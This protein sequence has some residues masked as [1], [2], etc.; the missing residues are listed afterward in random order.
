MNKIVNINVGGYPF[1]I[2]SDAY[3]YL[4]G[5]LGSIHQHFEAS[6]GYDE[7]TGDIETRLAELFQDQLGNRPIVTQADVKAAVGIMGM[8][9]EF[10]AEPIEEFQAHS[11][12]KKGIKTGK[13]L[14]RNSED[15]VLGGVCSGLSAYF[16]IK[17]PLW[18]RLILLILTLTSIGFLAVAYILLWVIVPEAVTASDRLAMRGETVNVSNI[19]KII[20]EEIEELPK[21]FSEAGETI[22]K[23]FKS[24][25]K[26][27]R[28]ASTGIR[29][30]INKIFSLIA[31][32]FRSLLRAIGHLWR[33]LLVIVSFALAIALI[34]TWA[35][36]AISFVMSMP[37]AGYILPNAPWMAGL[38]YTNL[39]L[40]IGIPLLALFFLAMRGWTKLRLNNYWRAGLGAFWVVNVISLLGIG[41]FTARQFNAGVGEDGAAS[42]FSTSSDT[43]YLKSSH[44]TGAEDYLF[45]V[46]GDNELVLAD[47]H[48]LVEGVRIDLLRSESSQFQS[49]Q[50]YY[51]R[52]K[53]QEEAHDLIRKVDF[54][55]D[56]NDN[57]WTIPTSIKVQKGEKYRAQNVRLTIRIPD[58]KHVVYDKGISEAINR[59][60]RADGD[61]TYWRHAEDKVWTM[62]ESGLTC[63]S[64]KE[65]SDEEEYYY[66]NFT[67]LQIDGKMK[68]TIEQDYSS[69]I[70][71]DARRK[72]RDRIEFTQ[73]DNTLFISSD[74]DNPS[75]PIRLSIKMPDLSYL[76]VK[77][78]D[79]VTMK[80]F[81]QEKMKI[82]HESD[83][84]LKAFVSIDSL[85]LIQA[86]DSHIELLGEGNYLSA[87]LDKS[88]L[89]AERYNLRYANIKGTDNS[90]FTL[91]V[92]D[93]LYQRLDETSSARLT[94]EPRVLVQ[95]NL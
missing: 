1:Q 33:P 56:K 15:K 75:E 38:G 63:T 48:L 46:F 66:N 12:T 71:I 79:D 22:S 62:T 67:N 16:G 69:N 59:F 61:R 58:G 14:F 64:M 29:G 9:E 23:E 52:G 74:V 6:E 28:G 4:S 37:L 70:R 47:D 87:D 86:D 27:L 36:G 80:G 3:E 72:Y 25:K 20:E 93:T 88:K 45:R 68:V 82:S 95:E 49:A 24:Q 31:Q 35:A 43:I 8:P 39:F 5:Y 65:Q 19:G 30:F 60:D 51:S 57:V 7:I 83:Y 18:V 85:T 32:V 21:R 11:R 77:D 40:I 76:L 94:P 34:V 89:N 81:K 84:E 26:N 53:N 17:D 41:M 2:D 55:I 50:H 42:V 78:T 91:A 92:S 10:G 44:L 73:V 54:S 13:R 90:R